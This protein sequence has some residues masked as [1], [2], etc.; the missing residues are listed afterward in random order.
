MALTLLTLFSSPLSSMG[1]LEEWLDQG[2]GSPND[3]LF[4]RC[5]QIMKGMMM[6]A[7][8]PKHH[9]RK[10]NR[11]ASLLNTEFPMAATLYTSFLI[12]NS[13]HFTWNFQPTSTPLEILYLCMGLFLFQSTVIS[14]DSNK[15]LLS[16]QILLN[17][18]YRWRNWS[19]QKL[20]VLLEITRWLCGRAESGTELPDSRSRID[21]HFL[22]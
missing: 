1:W 22:K 19:I 10:S 18:S 8:S 15:T 2:L 3:L 13:R 5:Q 21:L 11:L 4:P 16:W 17:S 9:R 20:K 14:F 7:Q 12:K 6:I